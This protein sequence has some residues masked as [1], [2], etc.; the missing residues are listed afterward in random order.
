[1]IAVRRILTASLLAGL[2]MPALAA[3]NLWW[4]PAYGARFNIEV[5]TGTN[6]PDKGYVG[7]T[8]RIGALDTQSLI[9]AGDMQSDCDD[10]RILFYDGLGW[11]ELPRH[12]L[13]CGTASTDVRFALAADIPASDDD[14]NYYLYYGNAAAGAG[15]GQVCSTMSGLRLFPNVWSQ[16]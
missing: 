3:T 11:Q 5:A 4:D 2:A 7:Y 1:M 6:V 8:V 16:S 13:G 9:A 14:D 15:S 10:L 12:V